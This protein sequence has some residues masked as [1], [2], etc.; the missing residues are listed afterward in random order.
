M[1]SRARFALLLSGLLAVGAIATGLYVAIN[2]DCGSA[3]ACDDGATAFVIGVPLGLLGVALLAGAVGG[4]LRAPGL[5]AQISCTI[6]ACVLLGAGAAIGGAANVLG[7]ALVVL[8]LVMGTLSVWV[9][10]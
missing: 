9:P 3:G 8:A 4:W 5:S 10:R 1:A 6:W 2:R 7:I